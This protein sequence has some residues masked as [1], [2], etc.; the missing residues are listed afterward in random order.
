MSSRTL[1]W[2]F[3]FAVSL[4]AA[5]KHSCLHRDSRYNFVLQNW[6]DT[7]PE[8]TNLFRVSSQALSEEGTDHIYLMKCCQLEEELEWVFPT[9]LFQPCICIFLLMLFSLLC[10]LVEGQTVKAEI[11]VWVSCF[12]VP[13]GCKYWQIWLVRGFFLWG[14]LVY[15]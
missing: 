6:R 14:G 10:S 1:N 12:S 2:G 9:D 8:F 3:N 7:V 5:S 15:I 4:K 13:K 11:S